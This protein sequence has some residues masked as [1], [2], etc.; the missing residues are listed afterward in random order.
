T[1]G[2]FTA[3]IT[4]QN[5]AESELVS[6]GISFQGKTDRGKGSTTVVIAIAKIFKPLLL[7]NQYRQQPGNQGCGFAKEG[8]RGLGDIGHDLRFGA[9]LAGSRASTLFHAL[10]DARNTL[11]TMPARFLTLPN[12]SDPVFPSTSSTL[13]NTGNLNIDLPSLSAFGEFQVPTHLWDAMTH[14]ACWIEPAINNEWCQIMMTYHR[15][16]GE[17][18]RLGELHD[19]LTWKNDI[20]ST[21]EVRTI[22]ECMRTSHIAPECVWTGDSLARKKYEIDHCFPYANWFNNDLWNLMPATETANGKKSNK[23]PAGEL[24]PGSKDRILG[25]W[26]RG[27]TET[28]HESRFY[29]EATASLPG[30]QNRTLDDVFE[31]VIRQRLHL[32]HEQQMPEWR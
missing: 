31:G 25:W 15:K 8:F 23:L 27:Y 12:S 7:D 3:L 5:P 9:S 1:D 26:E 32:K 10:R 18:V 2:R 22:V 28:G 21:S 4:V 17:T 20:R 30:I 14:Y 16:Q 11:K 13:R 6:P 24:L 19:A 29:T